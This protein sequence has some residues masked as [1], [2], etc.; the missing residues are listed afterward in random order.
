MERMEDR[1]TSAQRYN[2]IGYIVYC[3]KYIV[4]LI[5]ILWHGAMLII[6]NNP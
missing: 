6:Y 3:L 4:L 5:I 1:D 2:Y